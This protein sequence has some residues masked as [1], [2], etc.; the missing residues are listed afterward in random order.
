MTR[1]PM[2]NPDDPL[3]AQD[4]TDSWRVK[5][6]KTL[7]HI[8]A[9]L[10]KIIVNIDALTAKLDE[11]Q[12]KLDRALAARC[13]PA[14]GNQRPDRKMVDFKIALPA[15]MV[16]EVRT[17][18]KRENFNMAESIRILLTHGLE[19]EDG[20]EEQSAEEE[21]K[22]RWQNQSGLVG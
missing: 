4:T 7:Q 3:F 8:Q 5:R 19:E 6:D 10:T 14:A 12:S 16:D 11:I 13:P 9:K 22:E 20:R 17:F 2:G 21:L 18:A 1:P 15:D